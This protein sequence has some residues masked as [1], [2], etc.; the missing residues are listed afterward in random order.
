[1]SIDLKFVELT[2]D[3]LEICFSRKKKEGNHSSSR[4]S[5]EK[6]NATRH[7]QMKWAHLVDVSRDIDDTS[8][9]AWLMCREIY[10]IPRGTHRI[11]GC[12]CRMCK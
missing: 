3:V 11:F 4:S 9:Y 1:M 2:A 10:T 12:Q 5:F 7:Q 6:G 8:R